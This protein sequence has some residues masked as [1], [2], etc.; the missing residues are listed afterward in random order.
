MAWGATC[1]AAYA[2]KR[3]IAGTA[4]F[5][6]TAHSGNNQR[7]RKR[8][9]ERGR[10]RRREAGGGRLPTA[11]PTTTQTRISAQQRHRRH[12]SR[13]RP[14]AIFFNCARFWLFLRPFSTCAPKDSS[15]QDNNPARFETQY[16]SEKSA[17][18]R[19]N[20]KPSTNDGDNS[21]S[22][23]PSQSLAHHTSTSLV[24]PRP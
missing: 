1:I 3:E 5:K 13:L 9:L 7:P 2:T 15:S 19:T 6:A 16:V 4:T 24:R 11:K 8:C 14:P 20:Y 22:P 21:K 17:S 12:P 10:K 18:T 23:P